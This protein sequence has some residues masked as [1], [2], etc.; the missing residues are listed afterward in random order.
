MTHLKTIDIKG[1][2]YV[3]V[4]ERL[5]YLAENKQYCITSDYQ[6]LA[7]QKLWIVKATLKIF[8]DAETYI[9]EGLAQE[10]ESDN[11]K[12]VN[13]TSALENCQTSA[14]GRACA[15]A[16][17]GVL[18]SIASADEV[19][20]AQNRAFKQVN[21]STGEITNPRPQ[22]IKTADG[23]FKMGIS[24][25]TGKPWYAKVGKD[26]KLEFMKKEQYESMIA[27]KPELGEFE[28]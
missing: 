28:F 25:S 3:T 18:E 2:P 19:F 24:K 9:Y 7:E 12:D 16:G 22:T 8:K 15:L 5:K 23:E 21:S 13:H 17:I 6:Y 11:Y 14:V 4:A 27:P 20:K 1:K 10:V 26:N